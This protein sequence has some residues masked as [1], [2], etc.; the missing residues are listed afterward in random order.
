MKFTLQL[1]GSVHAPIKCNELELS[2]FDYERG[3]VKG[4]F[5][6]PAWQSWK[7]AQVAQNDEAG[8]KL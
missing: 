2:V 3:K 6:T 8:A 4:V 5:S 1:N 7:P